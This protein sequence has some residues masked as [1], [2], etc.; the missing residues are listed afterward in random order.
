MF[1]DFFQISRDLKQAN[2]P[3]AI[4]TVVAVEKPTSGKVGDKAI[5]TLDEKFYG[6]IGGSCAQPTVVQQSKLALETGDARLI[7]LS[8]TP[9]AQTSRTDVIDL[10]MT[11]FSGGTL[12]IF[13]EPILPQPTLMIVGNLP[14]AKALAQ[15]GKAMQ[16]QIVLVDPENA[17]Q[18]DGV[19]TV[20][21]DLST[22][23]D[24]ITP[25][26]YVVVASH[27]HYDELALQKALDSSANYVSLVASKRRA[28]QIVTFLKDSGMC[29]SCISQ[30]KYPAGLDI[31]AVTA[32]EIALSIM[33][34]IVQIRRNTEKIDISGLLDSVTAE[35]VLE[36]AIDPVCGMEVKIDGAQHVHE[37]NGELYY[38]CCGGCK[39]GFAANPAQYL[40]KPEPTGTAKDPICGMDVNIA[41]ALHMSLYNGTPYYF[42]C[43]NCKATFEKAPQN[44]VG[45]IQL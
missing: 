3:F 22:F 25:L 17:V 41:T 31:Q 11:C 33:A 7:R 32:E 5:I 15:L 26:T 8:V 40:D 42:C 24:S 10:P 12:E 20:I 6:W 28:E 29:G 34:E 19:D 18:W 43:P 14:I 16:Y 37:H 36:K 23:A 35:A 21:D 39:A 1:D 44:Y 9:E 30:L 45:L 2:T 27:G 13:I 4:A 38:F